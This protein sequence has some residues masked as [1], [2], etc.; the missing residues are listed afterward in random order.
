[1]SN[2]ALFIGEVVMADIDMLIHI[3]R[4]S[5]WERNHEEAI[6]KWIQENA[7][8]MANTHFISFILLTVTV[9]IGIINC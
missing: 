5:E 1:M 3:S 2:K 4:N 8:A 9:L 7:P 6:T